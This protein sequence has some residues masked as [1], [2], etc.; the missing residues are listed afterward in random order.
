V[1][2]SVVPVTVRLTVVVF[3]TPDGVSVACTVT[4]ILE[5]AAIFAAVLITRV[6][7]VEFIVVKL[8]VAPV[9]RPEEQE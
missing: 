9:G 5:A 1:K 3:D 6:L 2:L 8:Q 7:D 4:A